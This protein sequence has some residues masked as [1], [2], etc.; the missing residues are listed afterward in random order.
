MWWR[1]CGINMQADRPRSAVCGGL[2]YFGG[3]GSPIR[4]D[5]LGV[6]GE[7]GETQE[8]SVLQIF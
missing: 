7:H 6:W 3:K 5:F 2:Q 4:R 8:P 1:L